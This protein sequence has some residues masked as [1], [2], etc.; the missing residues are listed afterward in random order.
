MPVN[1]LTDCIE[2]LYNELRWLL[3]AAA[4]W[5]A[6]Q[7][8]ASS[9]PQPCFHIGVYAMDSALLH[10][11]SLYE[12]FT[13]TEES[14]TRSGK[15]KKKKM[16]RLTWQDFGRGCRQD[17]ATFDKFQSAL[18]GRV[19]H[20][21]WDRTGYEEV[22]KEVVTLALDLLRLWDAFCGKPEVA[23]YAAL[24]KTKRDDAVDEARRVGEQYA[25]RGYQFPF[26]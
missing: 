20:L 6:E 25:G 17:S 19:M 13:S 10:A 22:K 12:F 16:R 1:V 7:R 4:E 9:S 2:D 23:S 26:A 3:C 24:L 14:I 11:R 5:D 15:N 8:R 21:E 18:H